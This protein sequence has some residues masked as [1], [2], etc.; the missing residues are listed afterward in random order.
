MHV[1]YTPEGEEP[2]KFEF[3]KRVQSNKAVLIEKLYGK[4]FVEF[5]ADLRAGQPSV[6][7][8]Q[9]LLWHLQSQIHPALRLEDVSFY[10]D[11]VE[12]QLTAE[13]IDELEKDL[14]KAPGSTEDKENAVKY[15]HMEREK[16]VE[17]DGDLGKV[18]SKS[19][20]KV[21]GTP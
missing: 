10:T 21:T 15:L 4:K 6:K 11:E 2:Q 19:S 7:A 3:T 20:M 17:R 12:L 13:E 16:A 14:E 5:F 9:V 8:I 1:I 18:K